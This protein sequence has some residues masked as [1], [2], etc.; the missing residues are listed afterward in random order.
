MNTSENIVDEKG[1]TQAEARKL[2]TNFC[3]NG[4]E[5]NLSEAAFV[6]GRPVEEI[7][8]FINGDE[9]I[10]DDLVMKFRGIAQQREI[11]I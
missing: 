6:L 3:R 11:E 8:E 4:F 1:T 2:L 5:N 7:E 9:E 10:D